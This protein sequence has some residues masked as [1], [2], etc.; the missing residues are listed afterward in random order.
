MQ[1]PQFGKVCFNVFC[2]STSVQLKC[3]PKLTEGLL[4]IVGNGFGVLLA[5]GWG[6]GGCT[7][8]FEHVNLFCVYMTQCVSLFP[9][10]M[11][12]IVFSYNN[13][14]RMDKVTN[15]WSKI[16]CKCLLMSVTG[17][18]VWELVAV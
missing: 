16:Q 17:Y 8:S 1:F 9:Q 6:E 18:W 2:S 4:C 3:L 5:R 13:I 12:S 11:M 10:V 15:H 7:F 14:E